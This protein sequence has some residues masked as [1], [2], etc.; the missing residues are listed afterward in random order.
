[1]AKKKKIKG[2]KLKRIPPVFDDTQPKVTK[3]LTLR[4]SIGNII[5][6][7]N[8]GKDTLIDFL[9][10]AGYKDYKDLKLNSSLDDYILP[11]IQNQ[12][13]NDKNTI[14][15]VKGKKILNFIQP[16]TNIKI[17]DKIEVVAKS[18][19][20]FKH[21][22]LHLTSNLFDKPKTI[23]KYKDFQPINS[24][25]TDTEAINL[26][27][28]MSSSLT[29]NLCNQINKT[30]SN[31]PLLR[32]QIHS[33]AN[34]ALKIFGGNMLT[35]IY[36]LR[37]LKFKNNTA[38]EIKTYDKVIPDFPI[39]SFKSTNVSFKIAFFIKRNRQGNQ[40]NSDIRLFSGKSFQQIGSIDEQGYVMT[41]L[42]KFK[43]QLTMFYEATE[44]SNFEIYSGV[45]TGKCDLCPHT[46]THPTSLRIGIGPICARNHGI[47]R[48]LYRYD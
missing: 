19:P 38:L 39:I 14:E 7:Y 36:G 25:F 34:K 5:T 40:L 32:Y 8:I 13:Q 27:N 21:K 42:E 11:L 15:K 26:C 17:T 28:K 6:H 30:K 47:D 3:T 41:K 9:S 29:R 45:E 1:M 18:D 31:S 4:P 33:I 43:P 37:T 2:K 12:F 46:L 23:T 24:F 10:N 20:T 35:F 16:K 44:K 48:T 22:L